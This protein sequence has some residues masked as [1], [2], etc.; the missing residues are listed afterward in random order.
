MVYVS[1]WAAQASCAGLHTDVLFGNNTEQRVAAALCQGCPVR[2]QC[3]A[4][5]LQDR[6]EFGVWGG[7]TERERR[8]LAK[9]HPEVT[10]WDAWLRTHGRRLGEEVRPSRGGFKVGA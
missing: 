6:L 10:N 4:E 3:L 5:A 9:R 8:T 2:L 1:T 7:L